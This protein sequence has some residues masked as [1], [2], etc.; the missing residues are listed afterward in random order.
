MAA[1]TDLRRRVTRLENET[2]SIYELLTQIQATLAEHT[3][4]FESIDQRFDGI[5]GRLD[6]IETTL[7]E[8][9]RRLPE[10]A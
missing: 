2:V 6:G 7:H 3:Q 10:P 8:V 9:I 5:D 4:R 1:D